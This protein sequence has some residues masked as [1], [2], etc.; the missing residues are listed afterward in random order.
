MSEPLRVLILGGYGVFGGRLARLLKD[1]PDL[2]LILAGRSAQ[3]GRRIGDALG[4]ET[5]V[6]AVVLDRDGDVAGVLRQT[7]PDIVV[8]ATGPFQ[9]YGQRPYRVIEACL[10]VGCDYLDLAD[11]ADFVAGV[12]AF[13]EQAK[14]G[15]RVVLSGVSTCPVLTAAAV[16]RLSE[17]LDTLQQV[18]AG[19]GPSPFSGVG[20]NVIRAL[21]GYAGRPMSQGDGI[22]LTETR[23]VTIAPPG[24]RPMRPRLFA[25][26]DTPDAAILPLLFP[27]LRSVWFGAGARPR[28]YLLMLVLLAWL[29]RWRLLPTAVFLAPLGHWIMNHLI[30]S[31]ARGGMFVE[32]R[33]TH[34]G[35]PAVRTWHL[36][37]EGDDGPF[38]PAMAAAALI[39]GWRANRPLPG[40]RHAANDL[41][42]ADYEAIFATKAIVIGVRGEGEGGASVYGGLLESAYVGLPGPIR[43]LH[44]APDGS[45]FEGRATVE[46]GAN[47]LA[48]LAAGIIGFPAATAD[49]PVRIEFGKRGGVE[50]W[51]RTFAGKRFSS[52]QE[53]GQGANR[54]L[55]VERFGPAAFG[56]SVLADQD[57]LTLRLEGWSF[58]GIPLPLWLGPRMHAFERVEDGRQLAA[59]LRASR[60]TCLAHVF[61]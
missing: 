48:H 44:D 43:D 49:A 11:G 15:G 36:V 55:L 10:E 56:M 39:K 28:P 17:T 38:I 35:V 13:D 2:N 23:I 25:N 30:W 27:S 29:V 26:V 45:A 52:T 46:R 40:A 61:D 8:D 51:T 31:E 7:R 60:T 4:A 22:A 50:T 20:L 24:H 1:E 42:L 41:D 6:E 21:T 47:P 53:A 9:N 19:I 14:M 34:Q 5:S 12:E 57:Q 3:Q 32:A 58:L 18:T 37:A 33:G 16:R 54:Y 59:G